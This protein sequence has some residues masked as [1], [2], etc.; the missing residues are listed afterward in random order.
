MTD[1]SLPPD[2]VGGSGVLSIAEH[3]RCLCEKP[4]PRLGFKGGAHGPVGGPVCGPFWHKE[5]FL[6]WYGCHDAC[7]LDTTSRV[8]RA[9]D[10]E[11]GADAQ[12]MVL[13]N[14]AWT[15]KADERLR[16]SPIA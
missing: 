2:V 3:W 4:E 12:F 6:C 9:L 15:I 13:S 11:K 8:R 1:Q 14:Y 5:V 10:L 7:K 16:I